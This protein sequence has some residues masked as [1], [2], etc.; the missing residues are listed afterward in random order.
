VHSTN[1][2]QAIKTY[3]RVKDQDESAFY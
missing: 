2:F 3:K 1:I